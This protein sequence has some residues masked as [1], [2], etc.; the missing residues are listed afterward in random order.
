MPLLILVG[1]NALQKSQFNQLKKVKIMKIIKEQWFYALVINLLLTAAIFNTTK[2]TAWTVTFFVAA[3]AIPFIATLMAKEHGLVKGKGA[4]ALI[5]FATLVF[6]QMF[7]VGVITI[8]AGSGAMAKY[9]EATKNNCFPNL[10]KEI[11][12]DPNWN[13]NG[14]ECRKQKE[15][16]KK[17]FEGTEEKSTSF[18]GAF[19]DNTPSWKLTLYVLF[20]SWSLALLMQFTIYSYESRNDD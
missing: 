20:S 8:E 1:L 2:S 19:G 18:L 17:F 13:K 15:D 9:A 14:D 7:D 5:L 4:G 12:K 3:Y 11:V 10:P 6:C 16:S